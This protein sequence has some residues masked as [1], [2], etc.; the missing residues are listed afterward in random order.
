MLSKTH[1]L[2]PPRQAISLLALTATGVR[3]YATTT[4]QKANPPS[5]PPPCRRLPTVIILR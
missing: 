5:P 1:T 2:T 4:K 3:T